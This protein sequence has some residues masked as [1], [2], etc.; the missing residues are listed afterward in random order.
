M[1]IFELGSL[2]CAI[3]PNSTT[4]IVGR[5][6]AGIGSAG[7]FSGTMLIIANSVPLHRRPIYAGMVGSMLGISNVAGPLLGGAFTDSHL[8][9]RWYVHERLI[10]EHV[11]KGD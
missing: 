2:L 6:I 8:T 7:I 3:A 4:L 9:W 10:G 11:E 1:G 5:A